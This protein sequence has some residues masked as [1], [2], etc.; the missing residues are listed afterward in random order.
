MEYMETQQ[1]HR[2][3]MRAAWWAYKWKQRVGTQTHMDVGYRRII[4]LFL[5]LRKKDLAGYVLVLFSRHVTNI[6]A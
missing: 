5:N 2:G 1:K 3:F 4:I 6:Q